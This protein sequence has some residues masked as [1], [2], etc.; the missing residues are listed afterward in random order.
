[1]I[2]RVEKVLNRLRTAGETLVFAGPQG[3]DAIR[4]AE[5]ALR[6][7]LPPSYV[8][9]LRHY[10]A[11]GVSA[12]LL[13]GIHDNDISLGDRGNVCADT[14]R[15][16]SSIGLAEHYVVI[17]NPDDERVWCL[18]CARR[19]SNGE[20]PVVAIDVFGRKKPRDLAQDFAAFFLKHLESHA[21]LAEE[22]KHG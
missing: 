5:N 2:D 4:K 13:S 18:D 21:E 10:G 15:N 8:Q 6:V 7:S 3:D 12:A 19:E 16:R 14:V 9:F 1:M 17:Y 22:E 20:C 11:G